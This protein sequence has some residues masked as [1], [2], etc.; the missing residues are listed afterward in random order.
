MTLQLGIL[1]ALVCAFVTNLAFF[2]KH[3]GACAAP[4]VD[5][6]HPLRSAK[7]L[8]TLEVVRDRHGRRDRRVGASTSPRWRW[9]RCSVVKVG[10]RRRRRPARRH[11]RA[12]LRLRGRPPSVVGRRRFTAVGLVAA[13]RHAARRP[14]RAL[15][16]LD[17]RHDRLR[18]RPAR[19]RRPADPRPARRR[20]GRAPRRHARRRRRHPL[21]RLRRRHQGHDRHGRRRRPRHRQP[22]AGRLPSSPRSPPSTPRPAASRTATP[23]RSSPSPAPPPTSPASPAASSSSAIRSRATPSASSL[24]A[25]AFVMVI[26]ASALTP[27]PV[28]AAGMAPAAGRLRRPAAPSA[29]A[30]RARL[31]SARSAPRR[32]APGRRRPARAWPRGSPRRRPRARRTSSGGRRREQHVAGAGQAAPGALGLAGEQ[33]AVL[34]APDDRHRH[35]VGGG[36]RAR[37]SR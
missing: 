6:R 24:Q 14:R 13:G 15:Q 2:Y 17:R 22:V 20:P 8:W 18:G 10:P 19:R 12:A 36:R 11:G 27:A 33:Q 21:R 4:P 1:L 5:I 32:S 3:R 30:D 9:R 23:S 35:V 16:L 37:G 31:A 34:G 25:L 7:A 28:R 26:V 29:P